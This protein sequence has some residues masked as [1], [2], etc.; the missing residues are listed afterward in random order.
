MHLNL[1]SRACQAGA[2]TVKLSLVLPILFA[3]LIGMIE[4]TRLS[5]MRHAADDAAYEAAR[6][7]VVP[8]ANTADGSR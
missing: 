4:F 3:M 8:R 6:A 7:V 2:T 1:R 5:N